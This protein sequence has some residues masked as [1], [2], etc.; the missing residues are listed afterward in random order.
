MERLPG[1]EGYTPTCVVAGA[2]PG[3]GLAIAER[4]ACEGFLSFILSRRPQ[5][6]V[7]AIARLRAR[8]LALI[9][10]TCDV[11]SVPSVEEALR[12]IKEKAGRCDVLIYNGTNVAGALAFISGTVGEMRN[13]KNGAMLFSGC[14]SKA[15]RLLVAHVAD[16]MEAHGIHVGMVAIDDEPAR[17]NDLK[18]IAQLCW[19]LFATSEGSRKREIRYHPGSKFG[20]Y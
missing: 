17:P 3:L 4:Y 16:E 2:G 14:G 12:K 18:Q 13:R 8:G 20:H 10:L 1:R 5:R 11:S 19:E 7:A 9:P 15:L 6:L